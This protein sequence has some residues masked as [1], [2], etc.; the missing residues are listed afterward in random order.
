M[1]NDK[2]QQLQNRIKGNSAKAT[3]DTIVYQLAQ[4]IG[5]LGD[6]IGREFEIIYDKNDKIS[7][8]IQKPIKVNKFMAL[9]REAKADSDRQEQQMNKAKG[10]GRK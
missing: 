7:K 6:L 8:I 2:L 5:S 4:Q 3:F 9:M 1:H 10:R